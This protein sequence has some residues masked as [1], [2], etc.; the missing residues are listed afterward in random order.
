VKMPMAGVTTATVVNIGCSG[1][2]AE[3]A[4]DA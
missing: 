2:A 1:A 3:S 4:R